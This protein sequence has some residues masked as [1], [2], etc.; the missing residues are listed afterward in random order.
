MLCRLNICQ[1]GGA[2]GIG[3]TT[4]MLTAGHRN[5]E[6]GNRFLIESPGDVSTSR[7]VCIATGLP[8]YP[9]STDP[10][11]CRVWSVEPPTLL[12]HRCVFPRNKGRS[13]SVARRPTPFKQPQASLMLTKAGRPSHTTQSDAATQSG[14]ATTHH[15][16][17]WEH[18]QQHVWLHKIHIF[19]YAYIYI[20]CVTMINVTWSH[21]TCIQV[22]YTM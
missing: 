22:P 7:H 12:S 15:P 10:V 14:R 3:N 6:M 17:A 19:I 21:G 4:T 1:K 11:D 5:W 20:S 18:W 9:L 13:S 2:Q 8:G 16:P